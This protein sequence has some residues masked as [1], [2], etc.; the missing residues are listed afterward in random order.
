VIEA[1][2]LLFARNLKA[3]FIR[4][5]LLSSN[6]QALGIERPRVRNR[7]SV[8]TLNMTDE[9]LHDR[10]SLYAKMDFPVLL[11]QGGARSSSAAVVL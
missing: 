2:S 8:R 1:A 7:R 10:V 9:V 6:S 3:G 5:G 4:N 11:L